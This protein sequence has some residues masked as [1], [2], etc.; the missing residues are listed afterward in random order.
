[1][2]AAVSLLP[3]PVAIWMSAL[4][5]SSRMDCSRLRMAL[6]CTLHSPAS[7]SPGIKRSRARRVGSRLSALICRASSPRVSGRKK[8]NTVRLRASGS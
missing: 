7:S 6:A 5:R 4:G 8:V 3:D 1:M 2:F